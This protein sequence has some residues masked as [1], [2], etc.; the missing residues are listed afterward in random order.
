MKVTI[1]LSYILIILLHIIVRIRYR[2]L[3]K[4]NKRLKQAIEESRI[5]QNRVEQDTAP[6][7]NKLQEL[8]V[9]FI[10]L[11]RKQFS[12]IGKYYDTSI[13]YSSNLLSEKVDNEVSII[14]KD[15]LYEVSGRS[16][17][18]SLFEE[19]INAT[20]NDII[21]KIRMD[22]PKFSDDDIRFIC[23]M[24]VGFPSSAIS[25]LMDMSKD[26]V[27]VKKHRIRRKF[28]QYSGDNAFFYKMFI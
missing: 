14:L 21:I 15:L 11:F 25:F 17:S 18:Q 27:R 13:T 9:L 8:Q 1:L 2:V 23:Y 5:L 24:I 20:L 7:Y 19:R 4:E 3:Q 6:L 16:A 28:D 22:F 10:S 12:Y 26:S